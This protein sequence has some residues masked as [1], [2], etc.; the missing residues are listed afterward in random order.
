MNIPGFNGLQIP[1]QFLN[2]TI[3][4]NHFPNLVYLPDGRVFISANMQV[5][6]F[7]WR[8]GSLASL[9]VCISGTQHT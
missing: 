5:M 3:N 9:T 4:G 6:I 7:D 1:S 8:R 2:D